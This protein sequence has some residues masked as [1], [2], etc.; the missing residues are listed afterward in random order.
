MAPGIRH[1]KL[2][3]P[4]PAFAEPVYGIDGHQASRSFS[5]GWLRDRGS[6]PR[7][8]GQNLASPPRLATHR[9]GE[10]GYHFFY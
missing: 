1:I 9:R 2:W 7:Y 3:I 5:E 6:N 4:S 8:Q 10:A